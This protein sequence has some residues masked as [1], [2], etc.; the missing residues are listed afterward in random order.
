MVDEK[1][2]AKRK[3]KKGLLSYVIDFIGE[4]RQFLSVEMTNLEKALTQPSISIGDREKLGDTLAKLL[5]AS[6]KNNSLLIDA[7]KT[8]GEL[9]LEDDPEIKNEDLEGIYEETKK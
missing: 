1:E 8:M 5:S 3:T 9:K 6:S 7:I 4:D 2:R